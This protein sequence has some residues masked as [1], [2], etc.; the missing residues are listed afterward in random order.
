M[1]KTRNYESLSNNNSM[2][3]KIKSLHALVHCGDQAT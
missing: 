3:N 1:C 2:N